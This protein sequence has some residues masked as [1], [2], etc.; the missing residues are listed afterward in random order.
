M[1]FGGLALASISL[2]LSTQSFLSFLSHIFHFLKPL[3]F[4]ISSFFLSQS[5]LLNNSVSSISFLLSRTTFIS[6]L[7]LWGDPQDSNGNRAPSPTSSC[8]MK[9]WWQKRA[10]T[11]WKWGM[12]F[13]SG[14]HKDMESQCCSNNSLRSLQKKPRGWVGQGGFHGTVAHY[15]DRCLACNVT[16]AILE[17]S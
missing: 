4:A 6:A 1:C 9:P 12:S 5:P 11:I 2:F 3:S 17:I 7:I 13:I 10:G 14:L 16:N 8:R 15:N